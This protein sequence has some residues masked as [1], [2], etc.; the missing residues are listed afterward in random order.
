MLSRNPQLHYVFRQMG[1]AEEAGLGLK[2]FRTTAEK[3]GLPLPRYTL[4]DPYLVLTLFRSKE[5]A[6]QTLSPDILAT[7]NSDER[8]GW[9]FLASRISTTQKE[10]AQQMGFEYRKAQRHLKKF[11]DLGL[12][13]RSGAGR[14]T[15][16]LVQSQ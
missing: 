7:L 4:E 3:F 2:T 14:S 12:I 1:L 16:Y 5:S 15:E 6:A 8:A 11:S 9:K 10:Y 13:T